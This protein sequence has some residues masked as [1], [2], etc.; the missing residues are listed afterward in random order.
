MRYRGAQY[1]RTRETILRRY[2]CPVATLFCQRAMCVVALSFPGCGGG[3]GGCGGGGSGGGG[4]IGGGG[5]GAL[6]FPAPF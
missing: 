3:G 2:Y 1:F 6:S 4:V 5:C